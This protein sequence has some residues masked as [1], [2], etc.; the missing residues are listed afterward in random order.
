VLRGNAFR[1]A[2]RLE[3]SVEAGGVAAGHLLGTVLPL[4]EALGLDAEIVKVL[5]VRVRVRLGL[6]LE[7]GLGT[8]GVRVRVRARARARARVG[9][10]GS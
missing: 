6:G 4:D 5:L 10:R 7:L 2:R 9:V 1:E 3:S 8:V